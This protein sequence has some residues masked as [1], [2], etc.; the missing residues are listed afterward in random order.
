VPEGVVD[1]LEAV[2]VEEEDGNHAITAAQASE[3]I[4]KPLVQQ[5]AVWQVRDRI[6]QGKVAGALL[7]RNLRCDVAGNAAIPEEASDMVQGGLAGEAQN[8]APARAVLQLAKE[9]AERLPCIH[10]AA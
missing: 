10:G 8:A 9:I 7:S 6:V 5:L 1:A 4:V 3:R 2:K